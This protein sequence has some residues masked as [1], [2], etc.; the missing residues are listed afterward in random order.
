LAGA[1]VIRYY[2]E[3]GVRFSSYFV[4]D[5]FLG[6]PNIF[7]MLFCSWNVFPSVEFANKVFYCAYIILL[8][9]SIVFAARVY[10][11]SWVFAF[12][13]FP[14]LYN[15][16][17]CW[18]FA[19]FT[20]SIPVFIAYFCVIELWAQ[21]RRPLY[22][23][24]IA[25]SLLILFAIHALMTV[26]ALGALFF[27]GIALRS[28]GDALRLYAAA[29]PICGLITY[30]WAQREASAGAKNFL[31]PLYRYY[32]ERFLPEL[33]GRLRFPVLDNYALGQ[34]WEGYALA[35]IFFFMIIMIPMLAPGFSWP[36]MRACASAPRN[37]GVV[38]LFLYACGCFFLLPDQIFNFQILYMRFAVIALLAYIIFSSVMCAAGPSRPQVVGMLAASFLHLMCWYLYFAEFDRDARCFRREF[39]PEDA[40]ER[41]LAALTHDISFRGKPVYI[42]MPSYYI[43]WTKGIGVCRLFDFTDFAPPVKRKPNAPALPMYREWDFQSPSS[44]GDYALM[45]YLLVR[46][47]PDMLGNDWH[48]FF[49]CDEECG[50]WN[51]C[52]NTGSLFARE[53]NARVVAAA[54]KSR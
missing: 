29:L 5:S 37:R 46:G 26:F 8:P 40:Q 34:D 35:L 41:T 27:Y 9:L 14:L 20:F 21:T 23:A 30:W 2:D 45:D 4:L 18:G 7:H 31:D 3:P 15:F 43:V 12:C 49:T 48:E 52:R 53:L 6:K 16:N 11:G 32:A 42:H 51:L 36:R 28:R 47:D 19:G 44:V 25:L 22:L 38:T 10:G 39:F 13:S 50:Q 54:G 1:T 17:T 33:W 24:A